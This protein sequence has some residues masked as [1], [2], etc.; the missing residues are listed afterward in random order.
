[1]SVERQIAP[2]RFRNNRSNGTNHPET[3][4]TSALRG[5]RPSFPVLQRKCACSGSAGPEGECEECKQNAMSLQRRA[6]GG[7][8]AP[9][10]VPPIV[11]DVLRSPGR[12][13]DAATRAFMEPRFG[14]DFGRVRVHADEHAAESARAVNA[15]AYTVGN[16]VV[17]ARGQY[18]PGLRSGQQ[19]L[20]HELSHVVQQGGMSQPVPGA[21]QANLAVNQPGDVYEQGADCVAD[22]VMNMPVLPGSQS[23]QQRTAAPPVVHEVFRSP[24]RPGSPNDRRTLRRKVTAANGE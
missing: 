21:A 18:S 3:D 8:A 24:G 5:L 12:P 23:G 10:A 20:A 11:H 17:F 14:H 4:G 16:D 22:R 6:S 7:G 13:L 19:L 2:T 9:A 15:M 1:M